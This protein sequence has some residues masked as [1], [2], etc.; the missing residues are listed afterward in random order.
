MAD[1]RGRGMIQSLATCF[2]PW[3]AF[4]IA[5]CPAVAS[6]PEFSRSIEQARAGDAASPPRPVLL[7]FSAAWCGW[8]RKMDSTTFQDPAVA[9]LGEKLLFVRIDTDEEPGL[10]AEFRVRGLPHTFVLDDHNRPIGSRPGYLS[11]EALV[12]FVKQS[13]ENPHPIDGPPL[14]LLRQLEDLTQTED[15]AATVSSA[16]EAL[17]RHNAP[18]RDA[19]ME[20]LHNAGPRATLELTTLLDDERLAVRAAAAGVLSRVRAVAGEGEGEGEGEAPFDPFAS[21]E[22]RRAQAAA[23]RQWAEKQASGMESKP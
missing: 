4:L 16:V 3:T 20:A 8:C 6:P 17:S 18:G 23:W 13:L 12:Q 15:P 22:A 21:V 10:T 14:E 2:L 1:S 7:F 9:E 19:L 11:A 5:I